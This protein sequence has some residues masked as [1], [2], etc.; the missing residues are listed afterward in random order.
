MNKFKAFINNYFITEALPFES[1]QLNFIC[2]FGAIAS[3]LAIIS[4]IIAGLPFITIVPLIIMITAI[5]AILYM[6]IRKAKYTRVL[7]TVIVCG[8]NVIFWPFLFFTIGETY[9]GMAAYFVLAVILDLILLKGITRIIASILTIV[10]TVGCYASNL[11]FGWKLL[12][13]GGLNN[14]QLFVDMIQSIFIVG[15]LVGIVI[16]YQTKLYQNETSKVASANEALQLSEQQLK[17]AQ[18]TVSSMFYA[19]PHINVL[20]DSSLKVVDCN[21]AAVSFFGF[22][23]KENLINSFVEFM[24]KSVPAYQP[25]GRP[26]VPLAD[27]FK[28]VVT[29]GLVKFETE[30]HINNN[31]IRNLDVEFKKIPYEDSFAI[32]GYI[33]DITEMHTREMELKRARELN[34]IQLQKLNLALANLESAQSTVKTMF[35]SNPHINILFDSTFAVID[36]NPAAVTFMG[37]D[38]KEEMLLG[39]AQRLKECIPPVL[40]SGQATRP[41][42]EWFGRAVTEGYVRL[43]TEFILSGLVRSID[44][45][46]RKIPYND[47]FAIVGYI[48]DMTEVHAREV[49]LRNRDQQLMEAMEEAKAANLAKSSFLATMSHEIRTPMNAILG[50]TEIQLQKGTL[51]QN[52]TEAFD[53]I[54]MSGDMLLGIINDILDLSRIEAGKLELVVD[55]YEIASLI[56]DTAQLNMMR[57]GSKPIEFELFVDENIPAALIGDA[58]RVKQILNNILSNAFKYTAAG[59]VKLSVNFEDKEEDNFITLILTV[60]DTGQGMTKEQLKLLGRQYSRFNVEANRT[61]E[62]TGLGMSIT[63]N[64]I[65][66]MGGLL[67]VESELGKGSTFTVHIPQGKAEPGILGAELA[68]NLHNF[69]TSS[70]TRMRR[71]QVT[72][73][74]MPYGSVLIVDDV[75]TNIYVAKG[76]L[77][78]YQLK[79]DSADSG[80]AAIDKIGKCGKTYDIVFMDHMMPKMDG[81]EATKIIRE[82]GYTKPIVALTAN[83]V[84]GQAEIFLGN[85]FDDFI[86][87]PID[88]RQLNN[89]LNKLIRDK[90]S[91]DV[92]EAVSREQEA[93]EEAAKP[94]LDATSA[95]IFRRDA[96]KAIT[97][98]TALVEKNDYRNEENL[99]TYVIYVHGMKS[100]LANIDKMDLSGI[101]LKLEAAGRSGNLD[102]VESDTPAFI[103]SL[104]AFAD[105]LSKKYES[106]SETKGDAIVL[107]ERLKD[108]RSACEDYDATLAGK[109]LKELR[110]SSWEKETEEMLLKISEQLLHSDFDEV[111]QEISVFFETK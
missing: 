32:V 25:N 62:G 89:V 43:K 81:I 51:D 44:I 3:G 101:A 52:T 50:I 21:P 105:E 72:R 46:L 56:S 57:V 64:L 59:E 48:L 30:L 73:E 17:S 42:A 86:S 85:G 63:Q 58:L 16:L 31:E 103:K 23:T 47:S 110:S 20:F 27:R 2:L 107:I 94:K 18:L 29:E 11:F 68:T 111:A 67:E 91:A 96:L 13:N 15:F 104:S 102:I 53:K 84:A 93:I 9:S 106:S 22:D 60:S 6:S 95:E 28:T 33:Y 4:R 35:E 12:S 71:V 19:N 10:I 5:L 61:T 80:Y 65:T 66:L 55:R 45:E 83:A 87:K 54:S 82:M 88:I 41:V 97:E 49:E 38:T 92:L 37:F 100:A 109:I 36:C 99:R 8:V 74:P 90:Q 76:L 39:L 1:R 40:S 24:V 108:I 98:L 14:Y 69:R 75:E 78:P 26:S 77:A 79:V 70:R 7:T 34:D